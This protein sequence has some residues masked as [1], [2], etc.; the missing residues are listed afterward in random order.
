MNDTGFFM[1]CEGGKID[2]ACH[3]NDAAATIHDTPWPFAGRR[4]GGHR[5][6]RGAPPRRPLFSS[7]A[8]TRPA[9]LTIGFAGTDYDTYL[10]L[11]ES[12]TISF[13]QFD[14]QYVANYKANGTSF[15]EVLVDIEE[16]F[17]L[18]TEGEEG[19]KLVLTDYEIETPARRLREERQ[20][21][22]HQ[23]L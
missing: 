21:H 6:R 14:E 15:E 16:L 19:D 9:A 12:Q 3:A 23:Q 20:R 8:T 13:A 1:M 7:P 18:K 10:S 4:P 2:W 11:L 5:L 22:R 17:G